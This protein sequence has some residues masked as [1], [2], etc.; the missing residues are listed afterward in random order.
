MLIILLVRSTLRYKEGLLID[1]RLVLAS[2]HF[3]HN[4]HLES[5]HNRIQGLIV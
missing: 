1:V 4:F 5:I 2:T 3:K